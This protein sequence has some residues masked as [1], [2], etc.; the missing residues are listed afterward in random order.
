METMSE[1]P[2]SVSADGLA[3]WNEEVQRAERGESVPVI[4]HGEHVAD[5]VPSGE[6][7]RL[8]ETIEVLSDSDLVRDLREGFADMTAGRTISADQMAADLA[9][10]AANE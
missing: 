10:R 3:S 6:I 9:A 1:Q 5:V 4:A 8:R 2:V 7:D